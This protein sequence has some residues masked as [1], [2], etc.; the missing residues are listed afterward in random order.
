LN[1]CW[2]GDESGDGGVVGG[3]LIQKRELTARLRGNPR[4]DERDK[5]QSLLDKIDTA[6]DLLGE[7]RPVTDKNS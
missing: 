7:A 6:L 2:R 1:D 4:P 3:L 5:I